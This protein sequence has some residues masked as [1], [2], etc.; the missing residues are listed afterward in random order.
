M[1]G[2]RPALALHTAWLLGLLAP[3]AVRAESLRYL[4]EPTHSF[5]HF[6][7]LHFGTSTIRGRLGPLNGE[8]MLDRAARRGR[9]QVQLEPA[10]IT[11]GLAVLDARLKQADLLDTQAHPQAWFVA[12]GFEFNAT[13]GV[14]AVRG[15]FTLRGV[16]QGLSLR[17]LR[18]NCYRNPLFGREVCGGDFE[19]ELLRSDFGIGFGLPFVAD[20]VRLLVQVEAL[21]Q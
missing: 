5:V 10:A 3:P 14:A 9:V 16:S 20:R 6:E 11:T 17:A 13:G 8:V 1:R 21:A 2:M 4:L 15:E 12:E 19:G 18:F 7:V